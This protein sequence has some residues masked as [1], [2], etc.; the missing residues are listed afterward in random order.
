MN[1]VI[2]TSSLNGSA[3]FTLQYLVKYDIRIKA[4][5]YN[6][7]QIDNTKK[8]YSRIIKKIKKIGVFGALN[9]IRM[10]KWYRLGTQKYLQYES[11]KDICKREGVLFYKTPSIN[12]K[13]TIELFRTLDIQ[14]GLSLGNGYIGSKIFS[15]P[16]YGML[17]VHHEQLPEYQNAQSIIWQLYNGSQQ[18]AYTIHKVD[19]NIDTGEIVHQEFL[20]IVLRKSLSDTVSYNYAKLW[21]HSAEGLVYVLN[22]FDK[23]Y[24]NATPQDIGR[25]YTTP[26][27]IQFVKINLQFKKMKNASKKI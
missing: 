4:V 8:R 10:R 23:L 25:K 11:I 2:L 14:L 13:Y 21:Q 3:A 5:V 27:L 24:F 17:N 18:T 9:G 16:K 20:P 1:I 19:K 22:N 7:G 12:C 26:S 6:R 15:I